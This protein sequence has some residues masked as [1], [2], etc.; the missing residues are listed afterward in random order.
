MIR[1]W[2]TVRPWASVASRVRQPGL[3][4]QPLWGW[5][6]KLMM[7]LKHCALS[8]SPALQNCQMS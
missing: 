3:K 7:Y 8:P 2:M 5:P 4:H 6:F 1:C